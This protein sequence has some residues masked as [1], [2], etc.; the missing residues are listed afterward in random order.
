MF[1]ALRPLPDAPSQRGHSAVVG[2]IIMEKVIARKYKH[3]TRSTG[4]LSFLIYFQVEVCYDI[5][6]AL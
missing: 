6:R 1:H 5:E 3:D 4:S 2:C